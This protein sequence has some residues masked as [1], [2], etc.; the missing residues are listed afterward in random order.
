MICLHADMRVSM[1]LA[2]GAYG[3]R[4]AKTPS[5]LPCA[6]RLLLCR[7]GA[8]TSPQNLSV[9]LA[10]LCEGATVITSRV[11]ALCDEFGAALAEV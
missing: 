10:T 7:S 9:V 6:L 5:E 1:L 3:R 4:A 11:A 8:G 2:L